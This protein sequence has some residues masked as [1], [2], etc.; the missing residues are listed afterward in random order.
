MPKFNE[1][2]PRIIE[3]QEFDMIARKNSQHWV[4]EIKSGNVTSGDVEHFADKLKSIPFQ[5]HERILIC[6][7]GV[8]NQAIMAAKKEDIWVWDLMDINL[9]MKLFGRFPIVH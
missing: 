1:V 9:L 8:E 2:S 5:L 6:L 7:S 4:A 3:G